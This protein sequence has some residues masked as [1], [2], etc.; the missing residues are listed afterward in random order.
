MLVRHGIVVQS[1]GFRSYLPI[2][3]PEVAVRFL[4]E[5]GVDEIILLDITARRDGRLVDVGMVSRCAENCH[6]PLSVG[7]GISDTQDVRKVVAAGADKVAI[8]G[9][10][11]HDAAAIFDVVVHF[12]SQC[13]IGA[14]DVVQT[15][16]GMRVAKGGGQSITG[17]TPVAWSQQLAD[18]GVG[19]IL[20]N[21]IDRD[22]ARSGYDL[23]TVADVANAT[24]L[25]VIALGGAGQ[26]Q[27]VAEL[28]ADTA[29]RAAALGN[30]LHYTEHSVAA[31]KSDLIRRNLDIRLD[32]QADYTHIERSA[33]GRVGRRDD[34]ELVDEVFTYLPPEV[35]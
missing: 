2:G 14:M 11:F 9:L 22:G 21:S 12:G 16:D 33:D 7:G 23:S 32:S 31:I 20:I 10:F 19:E 3:K 5:W 8:N 26:P 35:I 27:H 29:A 34:R 17:F 24:S 25:P 18:A 4:D 6:V 28:F 15:P 1:I 13:V 30:I